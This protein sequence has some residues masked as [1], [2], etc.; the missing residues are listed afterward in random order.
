VHRPVQGDIPPWNHPLVKWQIEPVA[1]RNLHT[2][3]PGVWAS[4]EWSPETD[5]EAPVLAW[6]GSLQ[7]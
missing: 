4:E 7:P 6:R 5:L 3:R 1:A 2:G